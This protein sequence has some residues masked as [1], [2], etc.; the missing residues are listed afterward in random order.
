MQSSIQRSWQIK[1]TIGPLFSHSGLKNW[2]LCLAPDAIIAC[3]RS[4]WLTV[5]AGVWAGLGFHG[6]MR[7]AWANS[8]SPTGERILQDDGDARW[9]RYTLPELASITIRRCTGGANEIR[10]TRHGTEQHIYGLGD[11]SQTDRCRTVL[12]DLYPELYREENF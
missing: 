8:A 12:R 3:P 2:D 4:L 6:A 7:R 9:H 11:R 10:M 1:D 5:K